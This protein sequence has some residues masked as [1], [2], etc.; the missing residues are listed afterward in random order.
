MANNVTYLLESNIKDKNMKY[1]VVW[2]LHLQCISELQLIFKYL[3]KKGQYKY[4]NKNKM[5]YNFSW[6]HNLNLST[7]FLN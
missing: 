7:A 1:S 4:K 3:I 6:K 2:T 5:G